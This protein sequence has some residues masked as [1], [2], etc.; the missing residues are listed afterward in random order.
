MREKFTYIVLAV[1]EFLF[2]K[3]W[4]VC[5]KFADQFYFSSFD[6]KLR[7]I[8]AIHNDSGI[9]LF[10]VRIFH[11]KV[12]G[13]AIDVYNNYVHYWDITFLVQLL[14]FVGVF[15]L[16]CCIWYLFQK[17]CRT[18]MWILF[19]VS[20][21]MPIFETIIT[22]HLP[23]VIQLGFI[24]VPLLTMSFFGW[25]KFLI[26]RNR[27]RYGLFI[28]LAALSLIWLFGASVRINPILCLR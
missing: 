2:L 14:S 5:K 20:L 7:L 19:I 25:H 16:L 22:H 15:G 12:V 27:Y 23:F 11:N 28:L 17:K 24:A 18:W 4:I 6:L 3:Q 26:S 10:W 9:P 21:V 13:T 8:E 1:V